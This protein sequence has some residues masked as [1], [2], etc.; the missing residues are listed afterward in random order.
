LRLHTPHVVIGQ[1]PRYA[2]QIAL[3]LS[4]ANLVW[5][6]HDSSSL[7][8]APSGHNNPVAD[9]KIFSVWAEVIDAPGI[10]KPNADYTLRGRRVVEPEDRVTLATATFTDLLAR[11]QPALEAFA[12][13]RPRFLDRHWRRPGSS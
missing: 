3:E 5:G 6:K 8:T 1:S 11:F 7:F 13:P 4:P 10:P 2:A 12:R 9:K